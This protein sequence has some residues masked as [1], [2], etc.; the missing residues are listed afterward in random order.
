M[1]KHTWLDHSICHDPSEQQLLQLRALPAEYPNWNTVHRH[2]LIWS[3]DGTWERIA[4]RLAE[5]V[6]VREGHDAQ[7]SAG[8]VDARS[9]RGAS[10]VT[11]ETNTRSDPETRQSSL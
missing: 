11:G 4:R 2:H 1:P 9:V 6:R 10:T 8:I 3:K 7:P 5:P